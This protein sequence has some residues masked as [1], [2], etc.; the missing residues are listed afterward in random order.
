MMRV[1][2][3]QLLPGDP[4]QPSARYASSCV[5]GY[6]MEDKNFMWA[7]AQRRLRVDYNMFDLIGLSSWYMDS[8]DGCSLSV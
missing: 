7:C 1:M 3:E 8:P 4:L 5:Y 2:G 6:G